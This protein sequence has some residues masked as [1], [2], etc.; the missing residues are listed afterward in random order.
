VWQLAVIGKGPGERNQFPI[1][2]R[3]KQFKEK[4]PEY[5]KGVRP[6]HGTAIESY[7]PYKG[8]LEGRTLAILAQ[9]N[10]IDKHRVVHAGIGFGLTG[11]GTITLT[12]VRKADIRGREMTHLV[13]SAELYRIL[14]MDV[15]D[16]NA[17]VNVQTELR[18]SI[19]FGDPETV[20]A[21]RADLLI[22]RDTVSNIIE[23]FAGEFV[24]QPVTP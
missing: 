22:C 24:S 16:P 5:L 6:E 17:E 3:P 2:D 8:G 14:S 7:Q 23:A 9:L 21:S 18:Y 12:N 1:F 11:P 13:D 10:D 15:I 19:A 4:R 20:A